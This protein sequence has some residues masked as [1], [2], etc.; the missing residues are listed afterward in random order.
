MGEVVERGDR[1][2]DRLLWFWVGSWLEPIIL[3]AIK[4]VL[5]QS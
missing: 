3:E 4:A 1:G 5:P 2:G